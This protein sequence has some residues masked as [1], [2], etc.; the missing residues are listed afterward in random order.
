ML[1][2]E[3]AK[4]FHDPGTTFPFT[5]LPW[6]TKREP[7]TMFVQL[8]KF[9]DS[10]MPIDTP[11]VQSRL[12]DAD[13]YFSTLCGIWIATTSGTHSLVSTMIA[14]PSTTTFNSGCHPTMS[15][16][17][18]ETL[19]GYDN[20]LCQCGHK[21]AHEKPRDVFSPCHH[22]PLRCPTCDTLVDPQDRLFHVRSGYT[23]D[24]SSV[25]GGAVF[26][27]AVEI[28]CGKCFPDSSVAF[29]PEFRTICSDVL[30]CDFIEMENVH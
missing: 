25:P 18:P 26:R 2:D 13:Y 8:P 3:N 24:Q 9:T 15:A 4:E 29:S 22:F 6:V 28:D 17:H 21:L 23:G 27:F 1:P 5:M 20:P 10:P 19:E 12:D 30:K 16:S 7:S 14:M 11:F